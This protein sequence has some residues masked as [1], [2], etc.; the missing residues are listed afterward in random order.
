MLDETPREFW[1]IARDLDS[2]RDFAMGFTT[3]T[4]WNTGDVLQ[5][6]ATVS[7]TD[8]L[9]MICLGGDRGDFLGASN[10]TLSLRPGIKVLH[11]MVIFPRQVER[12]YARK[13]HPSLSYRNI[14]ENWQVDELTRWNFAFDSSSVDAVDGNCSH[15]FTAA[16]SR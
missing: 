15:Y 14:E 10:V 1:A 8:R 16:D 5:G 9:K 13:T 7:F 11:S 6:S 2:K 12:R 3:R 4:Q